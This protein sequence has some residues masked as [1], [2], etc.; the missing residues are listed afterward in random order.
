MIRILKISFSVAFSLLGWYALH[1]LGM[2][3]EKGLAKDAQRYGSIVDPDWL[4]PLFGTLGALIGFLWAYHTFNKLV[5]FGDTLERMPPRD[6]VATVVG[7]ILGLLATALVALVV[8]NSIRDKALGVALI[9]TLG[10]IL[11][12]MGV[13]AM[14]S[15][16]RELFSMLPGNVETL[17]DLVEQK[18][19]ILDTSVII[20]GRIADIS[21]TGFLEGKLYVPGFVLDELQHIADSSDSLRRARGRRGLDVLN[22]MRKEMKLVV[23]TF[24][25]PNAE[26]D[27]VDL[28]LVKLA[29]Q[30]N[31]AI[32]TTDF[33]LNKVAELQDVQVLNINELANAMRPVVLPSEDLHVTLV[34]EGKEYNQ[35]VAYLDDGTM[36]VVE[37]GKRHIG[38]TVSVSVTSVLQTVAGKMIFADMK[39]NGAGPATQGE[40]S[41]NGR[42][43]R[44]AS[45]SR[46]RRKV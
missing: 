36:V 4:S 5:T 44:A 29:K 6:K 45:G 18:P 24:D 40:E 46:S 37:G 22:Q 12:Y 25:L 26:G 13:S 43:V 3:F 2:I 15:M 20:D 17:D 39:G 19:K 28:K 16:R 33:N 11:C 1:A 35:G 7:V 38:Q 32:L 10:Y 9:L 21:R 27:E 30:L 23:R 34:K 31:G 14:M 41:V 42:D 8:L